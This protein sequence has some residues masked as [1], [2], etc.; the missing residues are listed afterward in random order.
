MWSQLNV[1]L[2]KLEKLGLIEDCPFPS[3]S[4]ANLVAA[5]RK[6]SD[7]VR[8]CVDFRRLNEEISGNF[9]P[10]P[11]KAELFDSL[12]QFNEDAV[13]IQLDVCS[14][15]W[16]FKLKDQDKY[17]T[18]FYTQDGV[19]QWKVLP[20][21]VKSAPGI[22]QQA[23]STLTKNIGLDK[24]TSR[25]HFIDDDAYCVIDKT[26]A[27]ADLDKILTAYAAINLKI[28]F[29]KCAFLEKS[30][31]FMGS[32]LKITDKGVK[33]MVNPKNTDALKNE[34]YPNF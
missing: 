1:E 10:L 5:K 21:G 31:F 28:K 20:F 15:F 8:L 26:T 32:E 19:M 12:G 30:I 24:R 23:L 7:K 9:F 11:T 29:E 25:S 34:E 13:F 17:L 22:V 6:G 4:P 18:A 3:I 2:N 27:I 33:L 14:C 16:N